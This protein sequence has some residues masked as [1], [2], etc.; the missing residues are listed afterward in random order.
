MA[1]ILARNTRYRTKQYQM[2]RAESTCCGVCTDRV[3]PLAQAP[4]H[5]LR[6]SARYLPRRILTPDPVP[7]SLIYIPA[8]LIWGSAMHRHPSAMPLHATP[9]HNWLIPQGAPKP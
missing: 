9:M 5:P 3:N 6:L 4:M 7:A 8:L 2:H 1:I